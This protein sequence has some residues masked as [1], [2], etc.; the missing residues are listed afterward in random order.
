MIYA[1]IDPGENSG[2]AIINDGQ[3]IAIPVKKH[4]SVAFEKLSILTRHEYKLAIEGVHAMGGVSAQ[5]NFGLGRALGYWMGIFDYMGLQYE[6]I[7]VAEW[8]E[9]ATQAPKKIAHN[10]LT[11][12]Q[13]KKANKE[14][15]DALKMESFRQAQL[16]FPNS[17]L[18]SHD[19]ADAVNI[20]RYL[21]HKYETIGDVL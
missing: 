13:R 2:L 21:K 17:L 8:Q 4:R 15:K 1:A 10:G 11:P 19:V 9:W 20:C 7:P 14:H 6:F 16:A 12:A 5:A 3:L 18:P